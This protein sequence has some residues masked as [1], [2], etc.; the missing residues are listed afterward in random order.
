MGKTTCKNVVFYLIK[1]KNV[2][3]EFTDK[4]GMR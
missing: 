1:G 2:F 4:N 3:P